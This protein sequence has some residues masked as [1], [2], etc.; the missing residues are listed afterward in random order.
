MVFLFWAF[1]LSPPIDNPEFARCPQEL[2]MSSPSLPV[3]SCEL[4]KNT[5]R[6][7]QQP[8]AT[9][10]SC[11]LYQ[12]CDHAV[13][14][15]GWTICQ[16]IKTSLNTIGNNFYNFWVLKLFKFWWSFDEFLTYFSILDTN[17]GWSQ[18]Q[19]AKT[20]FTVRHIKKYPCNSTQKK[21]WHPAQSGV[22]PPFAQILSGKHSTGPISG[23]K[24]KFWTTMLLFC[25]VLEL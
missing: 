22:S 2:P 23:Q 24:E 13:L 7:H 17:T 15:S 5:R 18:S 20:N 14:I 11:R 4:N 12:T 8:L 6:C 1:P 25:T 9:H 10:L 16:M 19:D 21:V 3:S